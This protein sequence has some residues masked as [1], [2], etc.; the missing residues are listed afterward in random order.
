MVKISEIRNFLLKSIIKSLV[1]ELLS[2]GLLKCGKLAL[3]S[4]PIKVI[5]TYNRK[6]E[7]VVEIL[8]L[9]GIIQN[10]WAGYSMDIKLMW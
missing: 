8:T 5:I 9:D 2:F 6:D 10:V 1:L 3:N 4:T 7:S